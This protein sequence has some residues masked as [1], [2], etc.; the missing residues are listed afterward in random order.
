MYSLR[1]M[2][3]IPSSA[4]TFVWNFSVMFQKDQEKR[5]AI[6][7]VNTLSFDQR[8]RWFTPVNHKIYQSPISDVCGY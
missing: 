1:S 4:R 8:I 7:L 6:S 3:V 5:A 2:L